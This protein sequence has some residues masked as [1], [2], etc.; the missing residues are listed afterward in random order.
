MEGDYIRVKN[1]RDFR[2]RADD[3]VA[4]VRYVDQR[5]Q[6]S[7]LEGAWYGVSHFGENGLAHVFLSFEFTDNTFLVVSIEARLEEQD[8]SGYNPIKGLF[9]RYTKTV[10]LATEQD[11]IGL[12][13]HVRGEP[14]YL[15]NLE[16][17]KLYSAALLINFLREAQSLTTKPEFYNTL[18]DNCMTGLLAQSD[19]FRSVMS[20][21]DVRILLPGYSDE[22][23][24]DLAYIDTDQ[25]FEKVRQA[26]LIDPSITEV[27][28]RDFS[29]K[30]RLR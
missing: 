8:V 13:S 15:Y 27:E 14:V 20:W 25:P 17:P 28:D 10:V 3:V 29:K 4:K 11:V 26:A 6:L 18:V 5:Y 23:A 7:E 12:R 19:Q 30:I 1:V 2:Y 24:Y 9:R 16:I 22:M 21:L